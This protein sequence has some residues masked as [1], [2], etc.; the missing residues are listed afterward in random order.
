MNCNGKCHLMDQLAV[1]SSKKDDVKSLKIIEAFYPVYFQ[2][3][4]YNYSFQ[5]EGLSESQNWPITRNQQT[6]FLNVPVPPPKV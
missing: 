4:A 5:A 1:G 3:Y 6:R 2:D